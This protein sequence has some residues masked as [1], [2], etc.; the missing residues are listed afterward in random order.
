MGAALEGERH[1]LC[2]GLSDEGLPVA[3]AVF[4]YESATEAGGHQRYPGKDETVRASA[5]D[6]R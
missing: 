1:H 2:A 4:A 5:P 3:V 6:R